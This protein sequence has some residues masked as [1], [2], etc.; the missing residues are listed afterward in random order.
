MKPL[1]CNPQAAL[2]RNSVRAPRAPLP[3]TLLGMFLIV[4]GWCAHG[5]SLATPDSANP[6]PPEETPYFDV[7]PDP[8]EGFNR[9][10]WVINEGLFRG[11]IYPLSFVYNTIIPKPVRSGIS[12]AGHNLAFPVRAVNSCL[13]GHWPGAW[14]ETKRF[15]L[16][17]TL[18]VGGFFDPATHWHISRSDEDF[19]QTLGHWGTGPGFFLMLPLLGPS[20]GRDALGRIADSPLDIGFWIPYASPDELWPQAIRPSIQANALSDSA[21]DYKRQLDSQSDPYLALRT[22]YSLNRQRLIRDYRPDPSVASDPDPTI[23]AVLFKPATPGFAD[24][25]STRRVLLPTTGKRLSYSCWIQKQAAPVVY[26]LPGLGSY[27]LDASA[28]AFADL[29]YRNGYS[30]VAISNPMHP[31]FM[32]RASTMPVPGYG[33][34]DGDDVARVLTLIQGDLKA[35]YGERITANYLS[36][37][38]LGGY[39]TLLIAAREASGEWP[40][41]HFDRYVA[42]NPPVNLADALGHLDAMFNAPLEWPAAERP[43]RMRVALY[44][45]LHFA[46][47]DAG[48]VTTNT[49]PLTRVESRFLVG[50]VF[51]HALM[52]V[53][54]DSQRRQNLHVLT[55]DPRRF[56]RQEAYRE[57]LQVSYA[58]YLQRF[59]I[60]ALARAGRGT[61]PAELAAAADLRR[62]TQ[63]LSHNPKVRVQICE[64]DFLLSREDQ[65]WFHSTFGSNLTTYEV[66][67]HLGNLHVPAVQRRL[68][69]MFS[70]P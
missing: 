20:N 33:P 51:R 57:I 61:E 31:E 66:G 54:M 67:G 25:A 27:R 55:H 16:N 14:E 18:G 44:K 26:Y 30:V 63:A 6:R 38:S 47:A 69:E 1:R 43:E 70:E 35:R 2:T 39:L 15:G 3:A 62:V 5:Q 53:I 12:R 58:D 45:S 29:L 10:T 24:R 13:Q 28:V 41:L 48:L 34:A 65:A 49:I 46:S 59:M 9:G 56:A 68:V 50:L 36:G 32:A 42:I 4:Q 64:D 21:R 60:P 22:L 52:G 19:G 37:V 8:L 23:G 7:V 11:V 17:S 40:G